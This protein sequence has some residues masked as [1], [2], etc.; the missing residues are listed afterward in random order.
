MAVF[1][2]KIVNLPT[3]KIIVE[4]SGEN[5]PV[6]HSFFIKT[7]PVPNGGKNE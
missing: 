5:V 4:T 2:A 7:I 1:V 3:T 6:T